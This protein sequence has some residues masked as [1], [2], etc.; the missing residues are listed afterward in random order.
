MKGEKKGN[1]DGNGL[2]DKRHQPHPTDLPASVSETW[3]FK[4]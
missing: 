3:N 2:N 4:K 1:E